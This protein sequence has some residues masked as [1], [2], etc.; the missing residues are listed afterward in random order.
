MASR[1]LWWIPSWI[2]MAGIFIGSTD[3]LSSRR[4][5]RILAPLLR[6][7]FPEIRTET[8]DAVQWVV[9]KLGHCTEFGILSV[10]FWLALRGSLWRRTDPWDR[11]SVGIGWLLAVAYAV[12]DEWHQSFV[13]TRQGQ[14][15]DV[16]I[17]AFG[18]AVAMALLSWL[19]QRRW[20]PFRNP[21]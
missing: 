7:F 9:R 3:V 20:G 18:A 16:V 11:R 5:S 17:D 14:W 6:W 19:A 15:M 2:W 10:L 13:A 21:Q 8:L 1:W 12:S 4:T